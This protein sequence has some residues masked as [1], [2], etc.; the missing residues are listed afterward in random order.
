MIDTSN[1]LKV[2]VREVLVKRLIIG[3]A[4]ESNQTCKFIEVI[5]KD[6]NYSGYYIVPVNAL[7]RELQKVWVYKASI[8]GKIEDIQMEVLPNYAKSGRADYDQDIPAFIDLRKKY[9]NLGGNK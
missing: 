4:C 9:Y 1:M 6:D 8:L 5:S 7:V 3:A 2:C